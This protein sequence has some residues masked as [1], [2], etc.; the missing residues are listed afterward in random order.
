MSCDSELGPFD[1]SRATLVAGQ[2]LYSGRII[3][4]RSGNWVMLAFR[5]EDSRGHFVGEITD[6]MP[7]GWTADYS[8]LALLQ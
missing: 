1:L 7:I 8:G 5:N 4:D 2:S 6:P 3:R